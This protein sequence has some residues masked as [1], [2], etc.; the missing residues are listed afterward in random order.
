MQIIYAGFAGSVINYSF[1]ELLAI[2][3]KQKSRAVAD[4][5]LNICRDGKA[6]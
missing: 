3:R 6:G 4:P 5:A 2:S 1:G